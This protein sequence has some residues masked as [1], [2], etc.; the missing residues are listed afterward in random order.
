MSS[1]YCKPKL[2]DKQVELTV[3][4]AVNALDMATVRGG[5]LKEITAKTKS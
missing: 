1:T 4:S 5:K 2:D 3:Q